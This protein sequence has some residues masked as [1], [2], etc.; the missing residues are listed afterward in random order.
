MAVFTERDEQTVLTGASDPEFDPLSVSKINGDAALVGAQI[1]LS[2]GG[3]ITILADGTTVFDDTGFIWPLIGQSKADS[4]IA[5]ITDG[6]N[7][8]SVAISLNLN[9]LG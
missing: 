9:N 1:P 8:V 2:I 7:E 3:T 4:V 6:T 5:E